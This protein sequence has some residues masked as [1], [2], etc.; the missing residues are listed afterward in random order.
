[1]LFK[2][3]KQ[4]KFFRL[5]VCALLIYNNLIM[6]TAEKLISVNFEVFGRVQGTV[7]KNKCRN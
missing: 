2:M 1:M 4:I 6:S 3:S 7:C 5:F